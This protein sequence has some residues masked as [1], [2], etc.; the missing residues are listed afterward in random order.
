MAALP[1]LLYYILPISLL[2]IISSFAP[3]RFNNSIRYSYLQK[4]D[5]RSKQICK[6]NNIG[7]ATRQCSSTL[8]SVSK[9][10]NNNR[11]PRSA[12]K[13]HRSKTKV[14]DETDADLLVYNKRIRNLVKTKPPNYAQKCVEILHE[15]EQRDD[16]VPDAYTYTSVISAHASKGDVDEAYALLQKME[17]LHVSGE[18]L[19]ARPNTITY[20]SVINA[21]ARCSSTDPEAANQ[22]EQIL[23][24]MQQQYA[25]GNVAVK[26][27]SRCYTAV[28]DAWA[29]HKSRRYNAAQR[30]ED[31]LLEMIQLQSSGDEDVRPDTFSYSAIINAWANSRQPGSV[32]RAEEI[33]KQMEDIYQKTIKDTGKPGDIVP[34]A[35]CYSGLINAYA[36]SGQPDA[37]RKAEAMI[38]R[39][40][41]ISKEIPEAQPNVYSYCAV[42]TAWAKSGVKGA[43]QRIKAIL[44]HMEKLADAGNTKLRPQT[45]NYNAL[46]DAYAKSDDLMGAAKA[47][48]LLSRM[49]EQYFNGCKHMKPNVR[50]FNGVLFAWTARVKANPKGN[51]DPAQRCEK[52]L[53]YFESLSTKYPDEIDFQPDIFSYNSVINALAK[54]AKYD[55]SAA[56]RAEA[57][58]L[59]IYESSKKNKRVRPNTLTFSAVMN[60][61]AQSR[62]EGSAERAEVLLRMMEKSYANGARLMKPNVVCY[63]AIINA[64]AKSGKPGAAVRAERILNRM[65]EM[66][67]ATGDPD[68]YPN[69]ISF[70]SAI[71]CWS[72][73]AE[74]E[75][76]AARRAELLVTRMKNLHE[77]KFSGMQHRT[78]R[79][80]KPNTR[81]WNAVMMAYVNSGADNAVSRCENILTNELENVYSDTGD[82]TFRP[83]AFSY[84]IALQAMGTK[85]ASYIQGRGYKLLDRLLS[86]SIPPERAAFNGII[87]TLAKNEC[88]MKAEECLNHLVQS[89]KAG[90]TSAKPDMTSFTTITIAYAKQGKPLDAEKVLE[91]LE[92][93][94][95]TTKERWLRPSTTIYNTIIDAWAKSNEENSALRTHNILNKMKNMTDALIRPDAISY[96]GVINAYGR[97][98]NP[99]AAEAL[100]EEIQSGAVNFVEPNTVIMNCVIDAWAKTNGTD[101]FYAAQR[102]EA[103]L[104]R[105]E[106][107]SASN[108]AIK[109]DKISYTSVLNAWAHASTG[110]DVAAADRAENLL[111]HMI[112]MHQRGHV[113]TPP[114]TIAFNTVLKSFA[115]SGATK[116]AESLLADMLYRWESSRTSKPDNFSFNIVVYAYEIEFGKDSEQAKK[117]K[118]R[119]Q[120]LRERINVI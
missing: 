117:A 28:I 114:D 5:D 52:L 81:T 43:T 21:C 116:K 49:L 99:E 105:M 65:L 63:S 86:S 2:T 118:D 59:R 103:I 113:E 13:R 54:A 80:L 33:L 56:R 108:S 42:M 41:E 77:E 64:W 106:Q 69:V 12:A 14:V 85:G 78:R 39:M 92:E 95:A 58:L 11:Q 34:N 100:L 40:V 79:R 109:P 57:L 32:Q 15:I 73:E 102:A 8:L 55:S 10:P 62:E 93:L 50:S 61:L 9:H 47:E 48:V 26:P 19:S 110:H 71:N 20:S 97:N 72:S 45:V 67:K 75:P 25:A 27:N 90:V 96:S 60:A 68:F 35:F 70:N 83:D 46:I 112:T 107:E 53:T 119:I 6:K 18:N 94:Y 38:S 76:T 44:E 23:K 91:Q 66:Y 16:I 24:H 30:A 98:N 111:Q 4:N 120:R 115:V 3:G 89:Y 101:R 7:V 1:R 17:Q 104:E 88:F 82:T 51:V 84:C 36:Q 87:L 74:S 37:P 29:R 31:L 22:A